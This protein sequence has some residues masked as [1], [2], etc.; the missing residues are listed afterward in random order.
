MLDPVEFFLGFSRISSQKTGHAFCDAEQ[1][2]LFSKNLPNALTTRFK[3]FL[4]TLPILDEEDRKDFL[5]TIEETRK[6]MK[7]I[8][9]VWE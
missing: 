8:R 1:C 7:D 5:K 4:S 3:E 2:W 6:S 9:N